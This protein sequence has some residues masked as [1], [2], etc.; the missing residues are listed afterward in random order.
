MKDCIFCKIARG[1]EPCYKIWEDEKF[2]SF[3]SIFPNTI[4]VSV[5]I[6]KEHHSSYAFD[7]S[8]ELLSDFICA[9]KKVALL[10][11]S[12]LDDVGRTGI[13]LEGFGINHLHAKLFPLHGTKMKEWKPIPSSINKQFLKYE[14]YISSHNGVRADDNELQNLARIISE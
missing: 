1:E 6:S 3:L 12:K 5:V 14:G 10:L 9:V 11:D 7:L 8:D 2:L 4:G 13:V